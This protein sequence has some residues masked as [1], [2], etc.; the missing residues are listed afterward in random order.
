[1]VS[2]ATKLDEITKRVNVERGQVNG[3]CSTTKYLWDTPMLSR[4]REMRRNHKGDHEATARKV[5]GKS[6]KH[7]VLQ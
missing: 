7:G 2:K 1:M 6:V 4:A 3:T 5:G